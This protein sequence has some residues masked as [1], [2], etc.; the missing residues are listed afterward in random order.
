MSEENQTEG[1][2]LYAIGDAETRAWFE[3]QWLIWPKRANELL[4]TNISLHYGG[5]VAYRIEH[6]KE[7][8]LSTDFRTHVEWLDKQTDSARLLERRKG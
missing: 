2:E 5:V 4:T 1:Q 3:R 6:G 8:A 7:P